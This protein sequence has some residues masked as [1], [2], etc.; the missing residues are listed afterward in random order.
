MEE[1]FYFKTPK[2][3][4][5][6]WVNFI[7]RKIFSYVDLET[8]AGFY[9]S[10]RQLYSRTQLFWEHQ[11]GGILGIYKMLSFRC[12]RDPNDMIDW[13]NWQLVGIKE[14]DNRKFFSE[15]SFSEYY[16]IVKNLNFEK[17]H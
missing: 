9:I 6:A 5:L 12:F 7:L 11:E 10:T 1:K 4:F 2:N 16:K 14:G 13:I 3:K 15:M 17:K 8:G